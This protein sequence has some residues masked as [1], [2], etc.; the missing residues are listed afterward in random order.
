MSCNWIASSYRHGEW[1]NLI[2]E[3]DTVTSKV[4]YT[5]LCQQR[6]MVKSNQ[7]TSSPSSFAYSVNYDQVQG[8]G[9]TNIIAD[10]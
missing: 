10:K 7:N 3:R 6:K 8:A 2:V 5:E 9:D 4:F 1:A